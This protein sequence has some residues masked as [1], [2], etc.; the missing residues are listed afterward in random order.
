[1]PVSISTLIILKIEKMKKQPECGLS[2]LY[3]GIRRMSIEDHTVIESRTWRLEDG[4][5]PDL[6]L[7]LLSWD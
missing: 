6:L 4:K 1:M 5:A 7:P 2:F 3:G